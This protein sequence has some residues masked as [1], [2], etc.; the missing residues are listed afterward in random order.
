VTQPREPQSR[1]A[2][3]ARRTAAQSAWAIRRVRFRECIVV[4]SITVLAAT[5][6]T[7]D[8]GGVTRR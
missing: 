7:P 6:R 5:V 3:R 2:R 1:A 4:P 8:D